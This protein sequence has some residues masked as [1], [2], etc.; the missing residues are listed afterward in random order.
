MLRIRP[1][2]VCG[3]GFNIAGERFFQYIAAMKKFALVFLAVFFYIL[4]WFVFVGA[5]MLAT[6]ADEEIGLIIA[7]GTLILFP[8]SLIP[9]M[10]WISKLVF[11]FR[12]EGSSVSEDTLQAQILG[13]N[14]LEA[15]VMIQEK[16]DRLIATWNYVDA[17]WWEVLAKAGL[18]QVYELHMKFDKEKKTVTMIDINKSVSWRAGPGKVRLRGG[19]FRGIS[20]TYEIGKQWGIKEN[21]EL[22]KIYDYKFSS[23][24]I[25]Y[26]IMNTILRNGWDVRFGLW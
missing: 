25:K 14:N 18:R 21:F 22:G 12:G 9:F 15:P 23:S 10:Q 26:P 4:L 13:I 2:Y 19:F 8:I 1:A 17:R 16:D 6:G 11:H 5:I 20:S 24:E 7:L 3:Q